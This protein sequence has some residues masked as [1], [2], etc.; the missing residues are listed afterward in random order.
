M[1]YGK[2]DDKGGYSFRVRIPCDWQFGNQDGDGRIA[3]LKASK[4]QPTDH[5]VM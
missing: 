5:W 4:W 2:T 1:D 3:K